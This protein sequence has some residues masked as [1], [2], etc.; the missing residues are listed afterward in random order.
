MASPGISMSQ[1]DNDHIIVG[2]WSYGIIYVFSTNNHTLTQLHYI[3]P[4]LDTKYG[5]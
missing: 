1:I 3:Q 2:C 4:Y 5:V